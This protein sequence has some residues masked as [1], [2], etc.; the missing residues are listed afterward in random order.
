MIIVYLFIEINYNLALIRPQIK[1]RV[2]Q[3][4]K[5]K[6]KEYIR[7]YILLFSPWNHQKAKDFLMISGRIK[8]N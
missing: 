6:K 7:T 4:K 2:S 3:I 1:V 5:K 8:F